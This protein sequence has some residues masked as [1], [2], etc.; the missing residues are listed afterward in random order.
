MIALLIGFG[1]V[2]LSAQERVEITGTVTDASDGAPLPGASIL[3]QG[4][5]EATG[6]TIGTTTDIDGAYSIQVPEE[7][8]TLVISFIGYI[9]QQ[10]PIDNRTAIDIQLQPDVRTLDDVVVVGYGTQERQQIT[11]S[12]SSVSVDEFV[13][14]NINNASELIQGKIPGLVISSSGGADPNSNPTL[15][16]RGIS[17]FGSTQDPLIVIDGVIGGSLDNIDPNDIE[18]IDVLKDAS[19]AAIYGT[20]G[21]AGVIVVTTKS[22]QL[23]QGQLS[24]SYNGFGT[25][26][27]VARSNDVLS[28]EEY[29]EFSEVSGFSGADLGESTNWFDEITRDAYSQVHSLA[30]SGSS[31]NSSYRVSG[32]F[33]DREGIQIGSGFDQ[34]NGRLNLTQLAFDQKLRFDINMSVTSRNEQEGFTQAFR[35]AQ[36]FNPTAPVKADGFETTGGFFEEAKFDYFNPVAIIKTQKVEEEEEITT[37]SL[38]GEY[39]F[40]DLVPG[41]RASVFYSLE[42]ENNFFRGFASKSNKITGGA[43]STDFGTGNAYRN[44]FESQEQL[45]ESTLNYSADIQQLRLETLAGYSYTEIIEE[46]TNASGGDFVSDAVGFSNLSYAQDFSQG[47]GNVGSFDNS[48]IVVGG[49]GRVNLNWDNTYFAN[50]SYRREASSWFGEGNKWGNF[51]SAGA[52]IELTSL[53]DLPSIDQLKLRGSYGVTGQDAPFSGISKQRF[54]PAGNFFAGGSFI[55][56]FAPVSNANPDLKWEERKELNVGADFELLNSRL[57]GSVEYYNKRIDDLLFLIDV[58]V[59]PNLFPQTWDNIGSIQSSGIETSLRYNVIQSNDMN[60][61]TNLT[62]TWMSPTTLEEFISEE[63]QFYVTGIGAGLS[64]TRVIRIQEGEPIGEIFGKRFAEIG[65][66][67]QWLFFDKDGNKVTSSEITLDDQQVLGNGLPDFQFGWTNS[68]N[69]KNW[70]L[71]LFFRGVFGHQLINVT[72]LSYANPSQI[73]DRNILDSAYDFVNAGPNNATLQEGPNY[74]SLFVENA[75]FVKLQNATIG[76]TFPVSQ[77]ESLRRL[78]IYASVNNAFTI[79]N[80]EGI[81]PEPRYVDSA[82]NDNPLAPGIERRNQWFTS[83]TITLGINLDF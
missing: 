26:E 70:D 82:N 38:R 5:Q 37:A 40:R 6:S 4:S 22:G 39:E 17:S 45:F 74:H 25:V 30:L 34:I 1:T 29:R 49:F 58:P 10:V 44:T 24:V 50:A 75:D 21:S 32:N 63:T 64:N 31:E 8:N 7:L 54:G 69:Y 77:F 72:R 35:Y 73:P 55:Q 33:R 81:S 61:N 52:G 76:Y 27:S 23:G 3:V 18:S 47:E 48:H 79:T 28:A 41:L 68:L 65:P 43:T 42:N 67:G 46:G 36:T 78:R 80:Y 9:T 16:L 66:E 2:E 53:I 57:S 19:A 11:G 59:P 13:Q 14:G 62:F 12:V 56:S 71:N 60:W 15:R 20:R 51:W 83:R